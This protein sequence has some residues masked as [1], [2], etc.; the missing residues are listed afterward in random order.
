M[1]IE[2][3]VMKT[4][5]LSISIL[6]NAIEWGKASNLTHSR[7]KC[8]LMLDKVSALTSQLSSLGCLSRE[9]VR[10]EKIARKAQVKR[11]EYIPLKQISG[12]LKVNWAPLNIPCDTPISAVERPYPSPTPPSAERMGRKKKKQSKP[13]CW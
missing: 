12:Q 5:Q 9:W 11:G 7:I 4:S 3:T 2:E 13:W 1:S 8:R 6:K 10:K